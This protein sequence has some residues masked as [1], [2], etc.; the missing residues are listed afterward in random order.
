M[1]SST[2][3]SISSRLAQRQSDEVSSIES[4]YGDIYRDITPTKLVWNKKPSPHFQIDLSCSDNEERPTLSVT[5]D[6]EFTA[7][8][9]KTP[10]KVQLLNSKNILKSKLSELEKIVAYH[11]KQNHTDGFEEELAFSIISDVK[12]KLQDLQLTTEKVLSLEEERA[13]RLA[14]ERVA[15]ESKEAIQKHKKEVAKEIENKELNKQILQIQDEEYSADSSIDQIDKEI[16]LIPVINKQD[17]TV[18][19][20]T[21][22]CESPGSRSKIKFRA[23]SGS[24]KWKNKDV[25]SAIGEQTIVKPFLPDSVE[26]GA[27]FLLT[28]ITL[29]NPYWNTDKGKG[30]IQ[31]LEQE[32]Q[33]IMNLNHDYLTKLLGFQIDKYDSSWVIRILTEFSNTAESLYDILSDAGSI[34]WGLGRHWLI[35]MLPLLEYLHNSG[36]VHKLICPLSISIHSIDLD[37]NTMNSTIL[38]SIKSLVKISHPSYA[39]RLLKMVEN[40]PNA[41]KKKKPLCTFIPESWIAPELIVS[42]NSGPRSKTDIWDLG[43]LYTQI[44]LDVD[45]L[46]TTYTTPDQFF[47]S[48]SYKDFVGFEHYAKL[49]YDLLFR[50]LQKK[51]TKRPSALELN[52]VQ[53]LRDGPILKPHSEEVTEM[54]IE[55]VSEPEDDMNARRQS[56]TTINRRRYSNNV[57]EHESISSSNDQK[58]GRYFRDF[59]E[60]GRLGKGG[61]GEVVKARNR[62]EGTFY[63]IKKIKHRADKLES[64]LSE[65]LSLARLNHQYIVRYY[66][67]WFEEVTDSSNTVASSGESDD[68]TESELETDLESLGLFGRNNNNSMIDDTTS[69]QVDYMSTSF[70]PRIDFEGLSN[71]EDDEDDEEDDEDEDLPFEF[72]ESSQQQSSGIN[73]SSFSENKPTKD[74]SVKKKSKFAKPSFRFNSPKSILYIQM[75]FCENKTLFDLIQQ[76]LP[77]NSNEYW[78]LFRQLL[79]AVSYIHREGFIHRDLKP[80]NIFMDKMNNI[81]VGDFGLAKNSQVV[82][83]LS[84]SDISIGSNKDFSTVVGTMFYSANEVLT[85]DYDEKVDMYALG[86][87]FFEMCH[88]MTTKMERADILSSLRGDP[89]HFPL[90][91]LDSKLKTQRDI[92]KSLLDHNPKARPSAEELLKSGLLPVEHQDL[93]I[94][95]ALKSLADPASPWQQHVR[96]TLFNQPYLQAKDLMFDSQSK[97]SHSHYMTD[98]LSDHLIFSTLIH[99]LCSIFQTHG[100]IQNFNNTSILPK[101]ERH[102]KERVYELLDRSGALLMLPYDLIPPIARFL[103]RT[104]VGRSKSFRHEFVFRSNQKLTGAPDKFSSINFDITSSNNKD[105]LFDDAECLKV[106]DEIVETFPSFHIKNTSA[107]ILINHHDIIDSIIQFTFRNVGINDKKKND[108]LNL[109]SQLGVDKTQEDIKTI[110]RNDLDVPYTVINE[111]FQGFY[112]TDDLTTVRSKLN[113]AMKDS[114]LLVKVDK[115][116]QYLADVLQILERFGVTTT[117]YVSPLS[118][119]NNKHYVNGIMFQLLKKDKSDS[120]ARFA[121]GGRFDSL[122]HSMTNKDMTKRYTPCAVGFTLSCTHMF[123]MIKALIDRRGTS[124]SNVSK[125]KGSRCDVLVAL[126]ADP[127]IFGSG[128]DIL[129]NLWSNNISSD[130]II[131]TSQDEILEKA[132]DDGANWILTVRQPKSQFRKNRKQTK[133][134]KPIKIRNI[135]LNRDFDCEYGEIVSIILSEL[136]GDANEE[137]NFKSSVPTT[138]TL[139]ELT[140]SFSL[141][142]DQKVVVV[143]NEAP[144]GRKAMH[145]RDKGDVEFEAKHASAD[146]IRSIANSPVISVDLRD[147][148][149]DIIA[150]T[151]IHYTDEWIR[152]VV[153]GTKDLPRQFAISIQNALIKEYSKGCKLAVLVSLKTNKTVLVNLEK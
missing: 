12:E 99:Q 151:S 36:V 134:Y 103:S 33:L 11:I 26:C 80:M 136:A 52:A 88:S 105:R 13:E 24:Q 65:V 34:D 142:I 152:K 10:P 101:G 54:A 102:S 73:S 92:I 25:L 8:Y 121:T 104:D 145:R 124:D 122:I 44:L 82:L 100:A 71:D 78:R 150:M 106:L 63:A 45:V 7:T 147:E 23:V 87:I 120:Y 146:Y 42:S 27:K 127:E 85:G 70:D 115:A 114:A 135:S 119:Y 29:T 113:K 46:T 51:I 48:F 41:G 62:L 58:L 49:V 9:P 19:E 2:E 20:N 1:A 55:D 60:V 149:L 93:I 22:T 132:N 69:L 118:N 143:Q 90:N 38:S 138:S 6:I 133:G 31:D 130:K 39:Y 37:D 79:E 4:I 86:I 30:E 128:C 126:T 140:P 35:Q 75:E 123:A 17:Y 68:W 59:E 139:Q 74:S 107:V 148:V 81:K 89:A 28:K 53:F 72:A 141:D 83:S 56:V 14:K 108:I 50:M 64:L 111:L 91:F 61:F 15:L 21:M 5:L 66:G 96:E 40:Q 94:K 77:D 116:F 95:A 112:I 76:G 109:L 129:N 67:A 18:F 98:S 153:F 97:H 131:A 47:Q 117:I 137:E 57:F 3:D 16:D 125:W 32:L 144:R 110:L 43:V 84:K